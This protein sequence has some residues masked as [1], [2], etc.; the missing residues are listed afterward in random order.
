MENKQKDSSLKL[1]YYGDEIK[2]LNFRS[3]RKE[4]TKVK[5]EYRVAQ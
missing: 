3:D 5:T 4:A 2:L 1:N